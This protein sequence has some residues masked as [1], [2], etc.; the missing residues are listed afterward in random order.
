MNY[1]ITW[2]FIQISTVNCF[3]NQQTSG[4]IPGGCLARQRARWQSGRSS[5]QQVGMKHLGI[6]GD[7]HGGNI[8]LGVSESDSHNHWKV[9][10]VKE[11]KKGWEKRFFFPKM[12]PMG[13][14]TGNFQG[15]EPQV[16]SVRWSR[17]W[18]STTSG[19]IGRAGP[20]PRSGIQRGPGVHRGRPWKMVQEDLTKKMMI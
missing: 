1:D 19:S 18:S 6:Y 8:S 16:A 14:M 15:I 9:W 2:S 5:W 12:I 4:R 10:G 7:Q 11:K 17:P 3:I 20:R 13:P